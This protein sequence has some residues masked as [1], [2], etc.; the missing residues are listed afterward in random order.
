MI[1]LHCYQLLSNHESDEDREALEM[2]WD[3]TDDE[4][5]EEFLDIPQNYDDAESEF[6]PSGFSI[7][8]DDQED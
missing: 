5:E 8:N 2:L 7:D 3:D 1:D 6:G 4:V